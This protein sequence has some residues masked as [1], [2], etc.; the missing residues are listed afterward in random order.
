MKSRPEGGPVLP[1]SAASAASAVAAVDAAGAGAASS[2]SVADAPSP[3]RGGGSRTAVVAVVGSANLD[4][5]VSTDRAPVPGETVMG[6]G[7]AE[8][9]GG[10][11]LNQALAAAQLAPT[12]FVGAVGD[13]NAGRLLGTALQR[14]GVDVGHLAERSGSSGTAFITVSADGENS[15]V[16]IAG[17]NGTVG[18]PEVAAALDAIR[19]VVVVTQLETP[20]DSVLAAVEWAASAGARWVFNPSPLDEWVRLPLLHPLRDALSGADPLIVN[21]GEARGFLDESDDRTIEQLAT[22]LAKIAA[23]VVVTD[24]SRG[25]HVAAG[26]AYD[27]VAAMPVAPIDT[28]GA[29]DSF[30]GTV[31]AALA[32]GESLVDAARAASAAAAEVVATPRAER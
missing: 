10:K 16:V 20:V 3:S 5:V 15:I 29:G 7:I 25:A 22:S 1:A 17:A 13:D 9:A 26:D 18:G 24:G 14:G 12:A 32:L 28:T 21:A 8:F 31:A 4:V 19:P 11:G 30:A 6:R 23:S 27:F 2:P